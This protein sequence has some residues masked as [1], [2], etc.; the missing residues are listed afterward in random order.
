MTILLPDGVCEIRF[1]FHTGFNWARGRTTPS[2]VGSLLRHRVLLI[3]ARQQGNI[4]GQFYSCNG[5]QYQQ[6]QLA[7]SSA[8]AES[9]SSNDGDVNLLKESGV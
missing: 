8:M 3:M 4:F 6:K 5:S 1:R 9:D 7:N 2:R